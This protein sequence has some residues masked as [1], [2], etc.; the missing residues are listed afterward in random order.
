M[1]RGVLFIF[2]FTAQFLVAQNKNDSIVTV[3]VGLGI[4]KVKERQEQIK[5]FADS[6]N[7]YSS[8]KLPSFLFDEC[9]DNQLFLWDGL[10]SPVSLRWKIIEQVENKDAL[11]Q[12][13]S[14]KDNRL[15][16]KCNY[17]KGSNPEITIPMINKSFFELLQ[18]RY[19]Q[20]SKNG[21]NNEPYFQY[22]SSIINDTT[23]FQFPELTIVDINIFP[24]LDSLIVLSEKCSYFDARV[25]N[26]YSFRFAALP[27][28]NKLLYIADAHLSPASAIGLSLVESGIKKKIENIGIFYYKYYLFVV[29]MGNYRGQKELEYFPFVKLS[30]NALKIRAPKFYN[31]KSYE[32]Y[33]RFRELNGG[34]DLIENKICGLQILI[35]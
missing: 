18:K 16:R 12:I 33:I 21:V 26:L 25:K 28:N 29:P 17:D 9:F 7:Y 14:S 31:E 30:G 19:E 15:K 6:L 2:I 20:L 10:H 27:E 1:K 34:Y 5:R 35:N 8:G 3:K 13:L 32:S 24:V 22:L 23:F 11:K 4:D